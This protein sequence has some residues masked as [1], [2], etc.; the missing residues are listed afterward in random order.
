MPPGTMLAVTL[1]ERS[2]PY[3]VDGTL[4]L[5]AVNG[6]KLCVISGPEETVAALRAKL[7]TRA[8]SAAN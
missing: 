5:A 8:R 6:P 2:K 1:S 4:S 3:L 7:P